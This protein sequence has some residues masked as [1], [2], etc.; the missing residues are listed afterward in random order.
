MWSLIF[1][2]CIIISAFTL[3]FR[4]FAGGGKE[5]NENSEYLVSGPKFEP[6]TYDAKAS[7]NFK[8]TLWRRNF[9]LNFSTPVFKM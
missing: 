5:T 8:L 3:L 7:V 6:E 2:N 9:L 1:E 4:Y